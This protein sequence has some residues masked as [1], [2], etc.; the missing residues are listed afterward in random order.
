MRRFLFSTVKLQLFQVSST[1]YSFPTMDGQFSKIVFKI[2]EPVMRNASWKYSREMA[3]GL[4]V[5][6]GINLSTRFAVL[7]DDLGMFCSRYLRNGVT[8]GRSTEEWKGT[9]IPRSGRA[10]TPRTSST[11]LLASAC[12]ADVLTFSIIVCW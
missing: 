3:N 4:A 2:G 1:I 6:L 9:S 8:P 7:I 11:I 5:I 12:L 10:A